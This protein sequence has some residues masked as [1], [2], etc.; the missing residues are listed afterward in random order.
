MNEIVAQVDKSDYEI[1]DDYLNFKVDGVFLD[2][3]LEALYPEADEKYKGLI[4][5]LL[6]ALIYNDE[7]EIVWNRILPELHGRTVCPILMCPDDCDFSCIVIVAEIECLEDR[8]VWHRLGVDNTLGYPPE[9]IG[10]E[11]KWLELVPLYQFSKADYLMMID[12]FKEQYEIDR[13]WWE[14]NRHSSKPE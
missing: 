9:I 5:T 1:Y 12:V 10:S 13:K 14:A 8:I 2:E 6:Y 4:P 7:K 3:M 11:V